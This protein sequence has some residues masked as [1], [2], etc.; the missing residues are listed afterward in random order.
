VTADDLRVDIPARLKGL[1]VEYYQDFHL[2]TQADVLGISNSSFSFSAALL[3]D[4]AKQFVRPVWD[5]D[6]R[7]ANFDP[8][9]AEPLLWIETGRNNYLSDFP[10]AMRIARATG[11]LKRMLATAFV[12]YPV[13]VYT[14]ARVRRQLRRSAARAARVG[15]S[16]TRA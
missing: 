16:E 15:S 8:W 3:N 5:L 1:G 7:L 13:S 4:R 9:Y 6:T 10:S 12:Y 11:G 14:I 2:M